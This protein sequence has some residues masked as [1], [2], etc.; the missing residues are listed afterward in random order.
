MRRGEHFGLRSASASATERRWA[1][2]IPAARMLGLALGAAA[3]SWPVASLVRQTYPTS[4]RTLLRLPGC[5][6]V[7]IRSA[8]KT[9]AAGEAIVLMQA[10]EAVPGRF[11]V[12]TETHRL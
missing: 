3:W 8:I 4:H 11:P 9:S 12:A 5:Q 2:N 6:S 7:P 1:L 10:T